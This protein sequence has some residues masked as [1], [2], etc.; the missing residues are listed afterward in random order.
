MQFSLLPVGAG[1]V[2]RGERVCCYP[3]KAP[4]IK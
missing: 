2:R 3:C 4:D 1:Q